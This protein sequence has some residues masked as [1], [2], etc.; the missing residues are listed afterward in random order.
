[1]K[2]TYITP[3]LH[4]AEIQCKSVVA[5]SIPKYESGGG[6]ALSKPTGGDWS[7]IWGTPAAGGTGVNP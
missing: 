1:M 7:D 3:A 4:I 5:T 6:T 2:K